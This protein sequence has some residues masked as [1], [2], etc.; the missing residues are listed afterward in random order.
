MILKSDTTKKECNCV[1]VITEINKDEY[2]KWFLIL[3]PFCLLI[4]IGLIVAF[5]LKNFMFT[6]ALTENEPPKKIIKNPAYSAVGIAANSSISNLSLL[7]P[8]TIEISNIQPS[9]IE[10]KEILAAKNAD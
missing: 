5:G 1:P 2:G 10:L 8:P 7:F 4:L 6:D 3:S 9:L